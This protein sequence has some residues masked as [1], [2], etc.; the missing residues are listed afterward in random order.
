MLWRLQPSLPLALP[1]GVSVRERAPQAWTSRLRGS[2]VPSVDVRG[3]PPR[4]HGLGSLSPGVRARPLASAGSGTAMGGT[5]RRIGAGPFTLQAWETCGPAVA[6]LDGQASAQV[7]GGPVPADTP[8]SDPM[9]TVATGTRRARRA[10]EPTR[11]RRLSSLLVAFSGLSTH[12]R[13]LAGSVHR[14]LRRLSHSWSAPCTRQPLS[15]VCELKRF[16][17]TWGLQQPDADPRI[18][19][20]MSETDDRIGPHDLDSI[21]GGAIVIH[22]TGLPDGF[23]P[24][25]AS[26]SPPAESRQSSS[27]SDAGS[28]GSASSGQGAQ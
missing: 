13:D 24:P 3:R 28:S 26:L 19:L 22:T 12:V 25:P 6:D 9:V 5:R 17:R 10:P 18:L 27:T 1:G 8:R 15:S 11:V 21:T 16:P 2:G 20:N 7:S 23:V 4:R 14:M